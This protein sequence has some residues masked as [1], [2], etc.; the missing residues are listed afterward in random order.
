MDNNKHL[1]YFK[2]ENF[3]GLQSFEMNN[4]GQF[5]LI[6]GDNNVGKTSILEALLFSEELEKL[7][8]YYFHAFTERNNLTSVKE[9]FDFLSYYFNKQTK[10]SLIQ[11]VTQYINAEKNSFILR[12]S[13]IDKL[14]QSQLEKLKNKL[15]I[16]PKLRYVSILERNNQDFAIDLM[17]NGL[18]K[19]PYSP[20]IFYTTGYR[21]DLIGFYSENIQ[22]SQKSKSMF[23]NSLN[24]FINEIEDIEIV[25]S[26]M[27]NVSLI[28]IRIKNIDELIPLSMFGEGANK[29]FR[30][31]LEIE[32][33]RGQRLMI[34]EID[35]GIHY[36]RFKGFWKTII[37][38]AINNDVQ[39][40]ASTHNLECL[41][42]FKEALEDE[43]MILNQDNARH[44][45]VE[46]IKNGETK[47]YT[48]NFEQFE[49][50]LNMGNE[51]RGGK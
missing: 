23:L 4:I 27:N 13:S 1:K 21:N 3:K 42:Y 44:F 12:T 16:S 2:I 28:Y 14:E 5:N 29:L 35:T 18:G 50:A 25:P 17:F 26:E 34:D 47:A 37:K 10:S 11:Y 41:K 45:L 32:M 38:S 22:K 9:E 49:T 51:V 24:F 39:I 15:L 7:N 33:V 30:I 19:Y 20:M 46:K 40:F 36:S 31:L 8:S 43:D 6:A 48:Y